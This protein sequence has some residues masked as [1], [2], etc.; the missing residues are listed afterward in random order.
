MSGNVSMD[1]EDICQFLIH[2]Y[3][4]IEDQGVTLIYQEDEDR[5]IP[6]KKIA[7]FPKGSH[8]AIVPAKVAKNF[9][10]VFLLPI[11]EKERKG[12]R[13]K[14][15]F[16]GKTVSFNGT[17]IY[18]ML[19]ALKYKLG[20][21][22]IDLKFQEKGTRPIRRK[23]IAR[24]SPGGYHVIVPMEIAQNYD[25]V[26]IVPNE[27]IF[28]ESYDTEKARELLESETEREEKELW[29]EIDRAVES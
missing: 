16:K 28:D 5:P 27:R 15:V 19:S 4:E 13:K 2:G 24:Y 6:L 23:D 1:E 12:I 22:G 20:D 11:K 3:L 26:Y 25:K 18:I 10:S 14:R 8:H 29:E 21:A 9:K 17:D 7:P